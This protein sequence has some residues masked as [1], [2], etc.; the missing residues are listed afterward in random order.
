[1]VGLNTNAFPAY[2]PYT[3]YHFHN[4]FASADAMRFGSNIERTGTKNIYQCVHE[5]LGRN[6]QCAAD[7]GSMRP[8]SHGCS[9]PK[10]EAGPGRVRC[11]SATATHLLSGCRLQIPAARTHAA[12]RGRRRRQDFGDQKRNDSGVEYGMVCNKKQIGFLI[13]ASMRRQSE[14]YYPISRMRKTNEQDSKSVILAIIALHYCIAAR[15]VVRLDKA[16]E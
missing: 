7:D 10:V 11:C 12:D 5:T 6:E 14:T 4:F 9:R 16:D 15:K 1:M 8:E 3:G 13:D 2:G